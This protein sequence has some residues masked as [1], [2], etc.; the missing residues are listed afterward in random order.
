MR[1]PAA[2]TIH[3]IAAAAGISGRRRAL[4]SIRRTGI[5]THSTE[6]CGIM[7]P[8]PVPMIAA[9]VPIR[10]RTVHSTR[11]VRTVRT[12]HSREIPIR[13]A[14]IR[15]SPINRILMRIRIRQVPGKTAEKQ[16]ER[17]DARPERQGAAKQGQEPEENG[18][19]LLP[20]RLCSA[21]SRAPS[22]MG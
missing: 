11:T 13:E 19:P 16:N 7:P 5:L 10:I 12:M 9:A 6:E 20:W 22:P 3:G 14:R 2:R 15:D 21:L 1:I 18:R 8:S 4:R 17:Q